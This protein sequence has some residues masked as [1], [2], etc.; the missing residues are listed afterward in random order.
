MATE[1]STVTSDWAWSPDVQA[2]AAEDSI[3]TA[4]INTIT[5][6]GADIEG[7]QPAIRVPVVI[8]DAA[9]TVA[10]LATIPLAD[11]ELN[12]R[13]VLTTKIAKLMKLSREQF[14]QERAAEILANAAT[15]SII[16]KADSVLLSQAV[17]TAPATTPPAGILN[18][19]IT[20]AG[21]LSAPLDE[22]I[23]VLATLRAKGGDP[24][25]LVL[26]PTAWA[27]LQQLKTGTGS[28]MTLLGAGTHDTT[29]MLLGVPIVIN[30]QMPTATGL[31]VDKSD[32]VSAIGPLLVTP[33]E[34]AY[35]AQDAIGLRITFRFGATVVHKD[36]HAKFATA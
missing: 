5:T 19:G 36:R 22:L 34:S 25:H 30:N 10:E 20:D 18:Q 13:I 3:P 24:S 17:P 23:D 8:D 31:F 33:S 1:N 32:I 15:R 7:D 26:A 4:L 29:P 27:D 2:F 14:E 16:A 28:N 12:E 9:H 11:Q 35:F 21:T 6:K